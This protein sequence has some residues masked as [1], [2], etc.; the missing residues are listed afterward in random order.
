MFA[1]VLALVAAPAVGQGTTGA[2]NG[3][4]MHEGAPLPGVT[5]TI[6]SP[7][8]QGSRVAVTNVNGD[9]SLV[10]LPPGDYSIRFEM[11][12]M[13][14]VTKTA[15]V[16]LAAN[17]RANAVLQLS[18]IAETITVTATAPSVME[19]RE[20]QSNYEQ[21]TINE[22]PIQR[23]VT[24]IALLSPGTNSNGPSNALVM[25]GGFANDNLILVNGANV[26]ENLR[27]QARPLFIED[28]I[29]ETTVMTGSISAEYGRFT[30]GVVSSI[31]K[32][33]GNAF[34]GSFRDNFDNPSW[35]ESSEAGE[36]KADST[37][38][39]T[40]EAT[41]GG[42]IVKDRLWFFLAGRSAETTNLA[43][44]PTYTKST[45]QIFSVTT[46]DRWEAKLTGQITPKHSLVVNYL[47][48]PLSSTN[49]VQLGAYE[50]EGIDAE[51]EQL[52]DFKAA[53]YSGIWTS[54][55]LA[56]AHWS[57]RAFTFVG[58]GGTET[59][60]Y[61]GTPLVQRA[62]GSGVA[63]APYFCGVCDQ[64]TRDNELLT[65]KGTYFLS[66]SGAGTHNLVGG[67]EKF[68]EYLVS[69]NF[70]SPTNLTIWIYGT[71]AVRAPDNS[72]TYTFS[73]G[74]TVE[75][76][77]VVFPSLGSDLETESLFFNDK[78]DLNDKWAFNL[79]VR[80][81][82]TNAV[83]S[84]DQKTA[85]DTAFSPRVAATYDIKG[86]GRLKINASYGKYVG[87]LA[88]T[89]QGAGS[90]AGQPWSVY[91]YYDG[92]PI[93]GNAAQVVRGVID[94]FMGNGGTDFEL[95]P[96]GYL[97]I[98]GFSTKLDGSL[99]APNMDEYTIGFA[100]QVG[101]NGFIRADYVSRSWNDYYGSFTDLSTGQVTE[102][103]TGLTADLTLVRNT[104][105]LYREYQG[106]TM[107]GQ[108]RFG[109]HFS[110]GGN[111]TWSE[112]TG[113]AE[114][115][116]TAAGP[117]S[118]GGWILQYPEYQGFAQNRP[119]GFLGADSTH[120]LRL[121]LATDWSLGAFGSINVSL[122]EYFDTG[123]PYSTS[124]SIYAQADPAAGADIG[125]KYASPPTTV[126]YFFGDRGEFRWDDV[127]RTD[128]AVNYTL[129]ISKID[130]FIEADL[131][132]AFN[133]QAQVSGSSTIT[134]ATSTARNCRDAAGAAIR[135]LR[136]NPFTE[137]PVEGTNWAKPATFGTATSGS[138][139]YQLPRTYRFSVGVRF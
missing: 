21:D 29:E 7:N 67:Y 57:E 76:Y 62:G 73:E 18:T 135:C 47:D 138:A 117:Q 114:G 56:E 38:N 11:Q 35:T 31:T 60:V 4:V 113:N 54:N 78:W 61:L 91:Y 120:K 44:F 116:G 37:T 66:T 104:D 19:T 110:L 123:T 127:T 102:P 77:P 50:P 126:T 5:V 98:G 92:D 8:L 139:N 13:S 118:E 65:V 105:L 137:A 100:T 22:L 70:Q 74:D 122:L 112:L 87:R 48:N 121:W 43:R 81:D 111:Y 99:K 71:Q 133:E 1:F 16:T 32:S 83:D 72:V 52:E 53:H 26:Q 42:R 25:S 84:F 15:K 6:T 55:F 33:G 85:D 119:E 136:F 46:N 27:G 132:N 131:L 106:V 75:Y 101:Q 40:Y 69:N 90:P 79:G 28:A 94:W 124:G 86:D 109:Q 125:D 17:T 95:N 96:P 115:E 41:L 14:D 63:N 10:A 49:D 107:Q 68:N 64:E 97:G 129:P 130:M 20:V 9:Y 45:E 128:L 36:P 88:E 80:Y 93:V 89:V 59:D 108:Y 58:F 103:I 30:G 12:G 3:T 51:I 39:E 82:K 134:T 24:A 34:S 2:L 23:N